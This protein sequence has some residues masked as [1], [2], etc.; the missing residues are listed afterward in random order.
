[1]HKRLTTI[2]ILSCTFALLAMVVTSGCETTSN[3]IKGRK[4]A[5]AEDVILDAPDASQYLNELRNLATGDPAIKAEI[6]A[7]SQAAATLTPDPSTRLRYALVLAT[8]GH[9]NSNF[10]EAQHI[11]NQLLAQTDLMTT[12]EVSLATIYLATAQNN[13]GLESE[14]SRIRT[15]SSR[16]ATTEGELTS[17]RIATLESDNQRLRESLADTEAKLE[18]LSSIERSIREQ[19]DNGDPR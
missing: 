4:T 11:L 1:M 8:A 14:V 7:D 13:A 17:R 10:G 9:A 2:R 6:F 15:S 12:V 3:W 18:A 16:A 19:T 5:E